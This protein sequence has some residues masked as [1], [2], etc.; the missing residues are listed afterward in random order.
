MA[1]RP[2]ERSGAEHASGLLERVPLFAS[3]STEELVKVATLAVPRRYPGGTIILREGDAGDTCYVVRSGRARVTRQ[4]PDGR[5]IT[6][7]NIGPGEIFGELAMFGGEVRSATV[8]AIEDLEALAILA[9]D[10]K[11][12]L[13]E[14]PEIAIKLLSALAARLREANE[15]VARQS[16]QNVS[17]RVAGVLSKLIES[18][19][20]T[21]TIHSD[22]QPSS[23][24]VVHST[25]SDLAKLAGAS[26]EATSRFLASL[27]RAGVVTCKRGRVIVHD[28][29]ALRRYIY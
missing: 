9:D 26:R 6:L 18:G 17:S 19:S 27:Q 7:T 1:T 15:R 29:Q 28:P 11:H 5:A 13:N 23:E 16:F 2:A 21:S 8:E 24:I 3:L 4:H 22:S 20:G 12:A 14:H 25:Q 10:L